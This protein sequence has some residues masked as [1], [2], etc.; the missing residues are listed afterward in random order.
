MFTILKHKKIG[1]AAL[2]IC[3]AL[4]ASVFAENQPTENTVT[5][6][7][8]GGYTLGMNF[9]T[10][11]E[12]DFAA[13]FGYINNWLL[14]DIGAGYESIRASGQPHANVFELRGHLG[15]RHY[16]DNSLFLTYGGLGSYGFRSSTNATRTEPYALG[17]F[18]GLDYQP[19]SHF[20]ISG[21]IAPIDYVRHYDRTRA[22]NIFSDGSIALSY[23]FS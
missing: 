10:Y 5:D 18:V 3:C 4:N 8:A 11:G 13:M 1:L 2:V 19:L 7:R 23:I 21:K 9:A 15:M 22:W 16:L 12:S 20:L 14:A 6:D 17:A